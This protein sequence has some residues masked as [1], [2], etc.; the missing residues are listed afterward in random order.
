MSNVNPGD[1]AMIVRATRGYQWTLGRAV[2]IERACCFA[3]ACTAWKFKTPLV[4]GGVAIGC[5]PDAFLKRIEPLSDRE[6]RQ[7]RISASMDANP[8][9]HRERA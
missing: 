9:I 2:E 6:A 1:T 5:A 4:Q 7:V 3:P 8:R